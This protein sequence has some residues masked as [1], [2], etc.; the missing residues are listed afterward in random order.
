[1]KFEDA[2]VDGPHG[3]IPVRLYRPDEPK[4]AFVWM[5][6]GGFAFGDL[7]MPESHW[8]SQELAARGIVVCSVDYRLAANG[9]QYPVPGDDAH[10]VW[11]W[12]SGPS[13]PLG[14]DRVHFGGASAGAC[15]AAGVTKRVRDTGEPL[16][17]SVVLVYPLVHHVVPE[18]SDELKAALAEAPAGAFMFTSEVVTFVMDNY[19][20]DQQVADDP[21]AF[22]ANGDHAGFPPTYIVNAEYDTLRASGEAFAADLSAAGI[23]VRVETEPGTAHGYVNEPAL[24]AARLTIDRLASWLTL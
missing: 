13:R 22:A 12:A 18:A 10:A 3:P 14:F 16:P 9:V 8:V 20:G 21:Y 2:K 19:L 7:D 17:A 1:M 23:T 4:A 6:G 24:E 15:L 11:Q 5:H